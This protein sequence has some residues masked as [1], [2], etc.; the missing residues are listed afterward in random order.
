M[1]DLTALVGAE[2]RQIRFDYQVTLVLVD[3]PDRRERVAAEL[4]LEAPFRI[5]SSKGTWT[6][7]PEAKES[8][9]PAVQLLHL[10]V[11]GAEM[12]EDETLLLSFD[13]GS[14]LTVERHP[15]F[16]TWNLTGVGIPQVLVTPQR[17]S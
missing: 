5:T 4:Q 14:A 12:T 8:Y 6:V 10:H 1:P 13:D 7:E 17:R 11:S 16:E 15:S 2:V 9:A 3:G